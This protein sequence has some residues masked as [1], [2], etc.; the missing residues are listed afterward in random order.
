M[1][2]T[3]KSP[4]NLKDLVKVFR[5]FHA[6]TVPLDP[7]AHLVQRMAYVGCATKDISDRSSQHHQYSQYDGSNCT[8]WLTM[9]CLKDMQLNPQIHVAHAIRTWEPEQLP[10]SEIL[11]TTLVHSMVDERGFN[12][13]PP[14]GTKDNNPG[15]C[16]DGDIIDAMQ[17]TKYLPDQ[18]EESANLI[19]E[20]T[21]KV[22]SIDQLTHDLASLRVKILSMMIGLPDDTADIGFADEEGVQKAVSLL[23][24]M[25]RETSEADK[26]LEKCMQLFTKLIKKE[27]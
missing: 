19:G 22:K 16:W 4:E 25:N 6:S 15:R 18:L 3:S 17:H 1:L 9:S 20:L 7:D 11:V 24:Q 8:W 10:M 14:G 23:R 27:P 21:E 2:P 12:C 13:W 26:N 5:S